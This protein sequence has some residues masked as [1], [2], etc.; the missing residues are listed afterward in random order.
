VALAELLGV[1]ADR[2]ARCAPFRRR[3]DQ[4]QSGG[5]FDLV[6]LTNDPD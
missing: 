3:S 6:V 5:T 2:Y 1:Y 4:V